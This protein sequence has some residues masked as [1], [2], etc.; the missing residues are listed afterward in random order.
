MS[1]HPRNRFGRHALAALVVMLAWSA[2][3]LAGDNVW[4]PTGPFGGIVRQLVVDPHTPGT[5]YA[6]GDGGVFKSVDS[7]ANWAPARS[8][9][10]DMMLNAIAIDPT[11]SQIL[12]AAGV[13]N[14]RGV[15]KSTDGG[16]TWTERNT[17]MGNALIASLAVDPQNPAIVYA[18]TGC[19]SGIYKSADGAASW[20]LLGGGLPSSRVSSIAIDPTAPST[21][22]A[23]MQSV[24]VYKSVN[25]GATWTAV[26]NGLTT[27]TGGFNTL[28]ALAIDP[29]AP[30]T[31]Y[32]ATNGAIFKTTN[33]GAQW[34]STNGNLTN[35]SVQSL[36]VNPQAPGTLYIGV[37]FSGVH[38]SDNGGATWTRVNSGVTDNTIRTLALD[39]QN[40]ARVYAG[41]D[42]GVFTTTNSGT[43][44]T[45]T[46]NGLSNT[47]VKAVVVDPATP[48]TLYAGAERLGVFKSVDAGTTW[49]PSHNG[50]PRT[51]AG[52][53]VRAMAVNPATTSTIYAGTNAGMYKSVDG[54]ANWTSI[55]HGT[56]I[57]NISSI[58][59]DPKAPATVR[60]G[61]FFTGVFTSNNGGDT[62]TA[63]NVGLPPTPSVSS[64]AS[65]GGALL[66]STPSNGVFA[67]PIQPASWRAINAGLPDG[68]II[69][70]TA[71]L[72]SASPPQRAAPDDAGFLACLL[73]LGDDVDPEDGAEICYAMFL[74][75]FAGQGSDGIVA[76]TWQP[77]APPTGV[78][79]G[80]CPPI[81]AI[82][83]APAATFYA[84]GECGVLIG[85]STG[86]QMAA[87]NAGMPPNLQVSSLAVTPSGTDIYAGTEGGGVFRFT[88]SGAS[89]TVDVVEYYNETFDHYFIT[90]V[91]AEQANLD[92]GNT[93]T[94]WTRTGLS[95]KAHT[96]T[97]AGSSPVCR[98]YIPPQLGDSHFFGRGTDECNA[99]GQ[100]NPSF[101]LESPDFMQMFLP[102]NGVCPPNTTQVYRVFSGR[103]DANHRYMTDKLVRNMMVTKGWQVEG[104]GPDA[105]VMCA[106]Q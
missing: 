30:A 72:P 50:I 22:Y 18:G 44:W 68:A 73:K 2:A 42:T 64:L 53:D 36:A 54:G 10:T 43:G 47:L 60:V 4:T 98:Y 55:D 23:G 6:A 37:L 46:S 101:V 61:T 57:R 8:G 16:A 106:P 21:L 40:P 85:T 90:W 96:T 76:N 3:V 78:N 58:V 67:T 7:G 49:N 32:A 105:V 9:I 99:T 74:I 51:G 31:L 41:T 81:K 28:N 59:I 69:G 13:T 92:A 104:D 38:R 89:A 65:G 62:W 91:A 1:H 93:P 94:K 100:K 70:A 35:P 80:D 26:N 52:L 24:G 77:L 79:P 25:G 71:S 14:G 88:K 15:F 20:T 56:L 45:A 83:S 63:D 29:A 84:G 95:F 39:P 103:P 86:M 75:E 87:M 11:N 5:L 102:V 82:A 19:C 33:G 48:T 27:P 17:G 12:Y 97:P 34:V 66:A